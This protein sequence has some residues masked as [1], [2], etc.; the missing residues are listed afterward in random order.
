MYNLFFKKLFL[1]FWAFSYLLGPTVRQRRSVKFWA[2]TMLGF[3]YL[4][5]NVTIDDFRS[6]QQQKRNTVSRIYKKK[7]CM[8]I[9]LFRKI[10]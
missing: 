6:V 2:S 1:S 8:Y 4:T 9:R 7:I 3:H 5:F 10:K